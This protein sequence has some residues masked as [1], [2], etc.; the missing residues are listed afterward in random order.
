MRYESSFILFFPVG[1]H[2]SPNHL[3][4]STFPPWF[5]MP[6]SSYPKSLSTCLSVHLVN[7]CLEDTSCAQNTLTK[8]PWG[9]S[10]KLVCFFFYSVFFSSFLVSVLTLVPCPAHKSLSVHPFSLLFL[11]CCFIFVRKRLYEMSKKAT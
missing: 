5:D 3:L 10:R 7:K 8:L 1:S 2:L 6:P 9:T 11:W 4:S